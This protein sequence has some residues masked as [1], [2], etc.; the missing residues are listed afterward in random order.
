ME[1][2]GRFARIRLDSEERPGNPFGFEFQV[3]SYLDYHGA[4]LV[5][6]FDANSYLVLNRSMDL[7]DIARNRGSLESAAAR[8]S[9]VPVL[10]LSIVSD[11]L[12]PT[13][14]QTT[15]RDIVRAG[16]GRCDHHVIKSPD[17]H[18]GFLLA[19][20]EVGSHLA[21]FLQEVEGNG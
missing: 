20:R 19:T 5:R 8:F 18:D 12:Y 15:M 9:S 10:T 16:G 17:G 3:E 11:T 14:Q 13:V 4:K 2:N 21:G 6:R 7:H 1:W